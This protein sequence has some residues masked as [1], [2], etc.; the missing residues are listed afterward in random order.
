MKSYEHQSRFQ[1]GD[2]GQY[3]RDYGDGTEF[4]PAILANM[5]NPLI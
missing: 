3:G 5:L 4:L 1:H 2:D